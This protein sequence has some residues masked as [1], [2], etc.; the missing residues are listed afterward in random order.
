MDDCDKLLPS[1]PLWELELLA[2]IDDDELLDISTC[3]TMKPA[4]PSPLPHAHSP[5][6]GLVS[7]V[8]DAY[9]SDTQKIIANKHFMISQ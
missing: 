1:D 7:G 3:L 8:H 2:A 4:K 9:A 6:S 5:E